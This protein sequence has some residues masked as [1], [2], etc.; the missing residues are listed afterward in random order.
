MEP[1]EGRGAQGFLMS[2]LLRVAGQNWSWSQNLGG[3]SK[4]ADLIGNVQCA[5]M[6]LF[7]S[8][9]ASVP[10]TKASSPHKGNFYC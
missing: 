7:A 4:D 6:F 8:F 2:W 3:V 1:R 10:N 9:P 5:S